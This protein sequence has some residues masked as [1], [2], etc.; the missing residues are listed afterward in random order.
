M[1]SPHDNDSVDYLEFIP[2]LEEYNTNIEIIDRQHQ[3][4]FEIVNTLGTHFKH[5]AT[6]DMFLTFLNM[7]IDY[8]S[9]HF[10]TEEDLIYKFVPEK[11]EA[12]KQEHKAFVKK[13]HSTL[14]LEIQSDIGYRIEL[15]KFLKKW[16]VLHIIEEDVPVFENLGKKVL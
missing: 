4:L 16:L 2:W 11:Y 15:I 8:S 3:E 9:E 14:N 10:A 7:L 12:H 6:K 1:S 5:V 13:I